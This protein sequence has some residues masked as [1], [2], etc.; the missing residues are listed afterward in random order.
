MERL[1][2]IIEFVETRDS[3]QVCAA[4]DADYDEASQQVCIALS[5]FVRSPRPG[6]AARAEEWLPPRA[7]VKEH[8]P[9][10]EVSAFAKEVFATWVNRVRHAIPQP[11]AG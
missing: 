10:N 6:E 9:R 7:T 1:I 8:L 3:E 11:A 4:A 2:S 5:S